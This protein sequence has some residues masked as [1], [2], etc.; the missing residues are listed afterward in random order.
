VEDVYV[1]FGGA[2]VKGKELSVLS[3]GAEK[4]SRTPRGAGQGGAERRVIS[5]Q[6]S[7]IRRQRGGKGGEGVT[8]E[9]VSFRH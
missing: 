3:F 1:F 6:I 8:P 9:G 4:R 2:G 7:A 5:D